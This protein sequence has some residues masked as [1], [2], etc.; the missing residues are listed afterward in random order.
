[1]VIRRSQ[2]PSVQLFEGGGGV[3]VSVSKWL[4]RTSES[5]LLLHY[6]CL[7][8]PSLLQPVGKKEAR[9]IP[10]HD[11]RTG[12]CELLSFYNDVSNQWWCAGVL[13]NYVQRLVVVFYIYIWYVSIELY[14]QKKERAFDR[15]C[16]PN[17]I[18]RVSISK[19]KK[20][21]G[22]WLKQ[23]SIFVYSFGRY[24]LYLIFRLTC[25]RAPYFVGHCVRR[26]S[27]SS[28]A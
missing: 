20:K 7:F 19:K 14:I 1:M 10:S 25:L 2:Q 6:V 24:C 4:H 22:K 17:R 27:S 9:Y 23:V 12:H 15:M 28:D 3:L 26:S 5:H 16:H 11:D 13:F 21:T 8:S 18:G